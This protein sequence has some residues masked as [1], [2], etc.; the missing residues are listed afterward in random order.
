MSIQSAIVFGLILGVTFFLVYL[1]ILAH[2]DQGIINSSSG[3]GGHVVEN[4]LMNK[5]DNTQDISKST[6]ITPDTK[7]H[8]IQIVSLSKAELSLLKKDHSAIT[9]NTDVSMSKTTSTSSKKKSIPTEDEREDERKNELLKKMKKEKI[10]KFNELSPE[11][12]CMRMK[13]KFHVVPSISWGTLPTELQQYDTF[14]SP[15][16]SISLTYFYR[17]WSELNCDHH[18]PSD[19]SGTHSHEEENQPEENQR[20]NESEQQPSTEKDSDEGK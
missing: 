1:S 15:F 12:A 18:L 2:R 13:K 10:S 17:K 6:E 11:I 14:L 19:H 9:T 8:D 5:V 20:T 7:Q 3:Q 16:I 4:L